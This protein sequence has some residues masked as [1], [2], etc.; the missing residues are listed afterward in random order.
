MTGGAHNHEPH[1]DKIQR[2][3]DRN[4]MMHTQAPVQHKT[5]ILEIVSMKNDEFE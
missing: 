5:E 3:I 1:T 4:N 2:I